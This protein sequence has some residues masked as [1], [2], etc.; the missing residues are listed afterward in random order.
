VKRAPK[1]GERPFSQEYTKRV[2]RDTDHLRFCS[3]RYCYRES[4][5]KYLATSWPRHTQN[6]HVRMVLWTLD[7]R[8]PHV[9]ASAAVRLRRAMCCWLLAATFCRQAAA[10]THYR[11]WTITYPDHQLGNVAELRITVSFWASTADSY[12]FSA[13]RSP[14]PVHLMP[15]PERSQRVEGRLMLSA[16]AS[17]YRLL[18]EGSTF[19]FCA[20]VLLLCGRHDDA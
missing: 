5:W 8:R 9:C 7:S 14:L 4:G 18:P 6:I 20:S 19:G 3:D 13:L 17:E 12:R 2:W 11:I 10:G 16:H 1:G 15:P